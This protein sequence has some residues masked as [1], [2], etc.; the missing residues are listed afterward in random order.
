[1]IKIEFNHT[2]YEEM[3]KYFAQVLKGK[4]EKQTLY[5]PPDIG[6]GFM[7]LIELPNG[8]QGIVSDYTVTQDLLLNRTKINK[9][10][11]TL[12]FDEVIIPDAVADGSALDVSAEVSPVRTAV[13]LGSSRF[14]WMFL[15]TKGTRVKGVNI[16]FGKEWLEQF[17]EVESVGDMI[18]K[19]LSL[20]MSAFN[21]EPMDMEYK[22]ILAEISQSDVDPSFETLII[23]NRIMLLLERFFTRIFHKM[24]DM[25]FDVKLSNDDINRLKMIEKELVKDFSSEPPGINKLARMAVM[26]P[27]KLKS[28]FKEIY[29]LPVYQYFQKHRMN[30]A[31]AMLLSRNYTVREVGIE[32]GYSNLSNFAKAFKKSFD[33]LPSDLLSG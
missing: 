31:K 15:I 10:F 6:T 24:S 9:D 12:R 19:Y 7:K 11:Y 3:L 16:L 30:K 29:G 23:Q 33:Q 13:F 20:R 21:Y 28:S 4:I 5:L 1:V 8:L 25:H 27:S 22:R 26:S 32:V 18:K 2:D 17:L 14:D